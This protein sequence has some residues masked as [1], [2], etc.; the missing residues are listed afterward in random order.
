ML[1]EYYHAARHAAALAEM[2]WYGILKLTGSE[3]ASWLQG[4]VTND[5]QKLAPGTGC[6]AAHLTPQGKIVAH[7][8][9]LADEDALWLSLERTALPKLVQAFD[10]LLIMEDAQIEDCSDQFD[11]LSVVGPRAVA[12][13]EAWLGES[14]TLEGFYSHR[15]FEDGRVVVSDLGYELWVARG[16]ADKV[17]RSLSQAG[18]TSID[19][20][21]WDVL[22]TEAG[23]PIYGVD[24]DETTTMPEIGEKGIS[25]NKGC[26]IGQEVVAK[27]KY[28]GHVNRRFVGLTLSGSDIPELKSPIY[29]GI[30]EVGSLTTSL[31][32]PG[33]ERPIALGFV[34]RTA[35][36]VGT[37][38]E[39]LSEGKRLRAVIVDLPFRA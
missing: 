32:S 20:G 37:E 4:M 1:A 31:F 34:S 35:Y 3:R 23:I 22:R 16:Q 7:M 27:V 28:I 13:L 39:I 18:A 30:K 36:S 10:K 15:N 11:I 19:H 26:Y 29:K 24:I 17:L 8:H 2:D 12:V 6:Y 33:L 38:V 9:I 21:A 14:L 25:Y 5:V